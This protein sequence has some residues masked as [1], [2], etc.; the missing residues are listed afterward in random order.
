MYYKIY[1]NFDFSNSHLGVRRK[2]PS[3]GVESPEGPKKISLTASE[4]HVSFSITFIARGS[5]FSINF[6]F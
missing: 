4:K 2:H 6:L 3:G 5:K 1:N